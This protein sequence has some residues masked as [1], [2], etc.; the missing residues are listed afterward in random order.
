MK[1]DLGICPFP[2]WEVVHL[3]SNVGLQLWEP[4]TQHS[5]TQCLVTDSGS[6]PSW[7]SWLIWQRAVDFF[8]ISMALTGGDSCPLWR[9]S[10]AQPFHTCQSCSAV[11][12]QKTCVHNIGRDTFRRTFERWGQVSLK[13]MSLN[14]QCCTSQ[15]FFFLPEVNYNILVFKMLWV[16]IYSVHVFISRQIY[17]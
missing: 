4:S 6:W 15:R 13:K 7:L 1:P 8:P 2:S 9:I 12:T 10:W 14:F 16:N 3:D 17:M 5:Y 11:T